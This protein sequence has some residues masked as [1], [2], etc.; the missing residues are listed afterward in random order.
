MSKKIA[1]FVRN[2]KKCI[3]NKVKSKNRE[4]LVLT[5][6]PNRAFEIVVLDTIDAFTESRKQICVNSYMCVT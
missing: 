3:L 2:C 4:K 6:T 1:T 5:P